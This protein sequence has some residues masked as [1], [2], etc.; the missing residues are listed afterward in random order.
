MKLEDSKLNCQIPCLKHI[1]EGLA[2]GPVFPLAT[3]I[4][5]SIRR[6][7]SPNLERRLKNSTNRELNRLCRLTGK[8]PKPYRPLPERPPG[9]LQPGDIVRV[10]TLKEIKATL[11]HWGQVKGC[12]FMQ[13]MAE[14]CGTTQKVFKRMERFVDERDLQIKKSNGIIFLENVMCRG[15]KNFGDCDRA[16]FHFWREEWIERINETSMHGDLEIEQKS[17]EGEW[18][19]VRSLEMIEATLDNSQKLKGCAFMPEMANYCGTKQK[20]LKRIRRYI[21]ESEFRVKKADGIVL[22]EN[23]M[24]HGIGDLSRCDRACFYLWREEWLREA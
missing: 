11:N 4:K 6:F 12:G 8:N 2:K 19:Q 23:V 1:D 14:F 20:V 5:L 16:C 15:A 9:G 18:V 13:E 3:R 24:C 7:L 17:Q 21:D 10:R 22:L